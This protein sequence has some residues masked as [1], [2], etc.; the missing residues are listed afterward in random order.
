MY[1]RILDMLLR[2]ILIEVEYSKEI[3]NPDEAILIIKYLESI[4]NDYNSRKLVEAYSIS[5]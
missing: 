4:I 5:K 3:L 2:S 1:G